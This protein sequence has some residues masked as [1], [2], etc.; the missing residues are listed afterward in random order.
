MEVEVEAHPGRGMRAPWL[1][2]RHAVNRASRDAAASGTHVP[3]SPGACA[4]LDPIARKAV[5][6]ALTSG[7]ASS[8]SRSNS[9]SEGGGGSAKAGGKTAG[10]SGG[11]GHLQGRPPQRQR[12]PLQHALGAHG[13]PQ[14]RHLRD[15]GQVQLEELVGKQLGDVAR[16]VIVLLQVGAGGQVGWGS[17]AVGHE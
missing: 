4:M 1:P 14:R 3:A 11:E 10:C 12:A 15:E 13:A 6:S 16:Q 2:C 8:S 17:C 7:P 9:S 5:S